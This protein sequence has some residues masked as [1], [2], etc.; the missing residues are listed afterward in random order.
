MSHE[1]PPEDRQQD[2][3]SPGSLW[4]AFSSRFHAIAFF[5]YMLLIPLAWIVAFKRRQYVVVAGIVLGFCSFFV[6]SMDWY[7]DMEP[8]LVAG[9]CFGVVYI[10][11]LYASYRRPE[12]ERANEE[13]VQ[14]EREAR[15]NQR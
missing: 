13:R 5:L 15:K 6:L 11:A 9:G 14:R 4:R 10:P 8:M 2:W 12:E 1:Y 7:R 3:L